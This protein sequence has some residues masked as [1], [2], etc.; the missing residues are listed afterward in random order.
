M[1]T[2]LNGRFEPAHRRCGPCDVAA[3]V[4]VSLAWAAND[5]AL[6]LDGATPGTDT[7]GT[8]PTGIAR[9]AVGDHPYAAVS[10]SQCGMAIRRAAYFPRRLPNSVLQ[11][12]TAP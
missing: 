5:F 1:K 4:R 2:A 6:A 7:L 3:I 11:T 9:L 12:L 10:A 8:V